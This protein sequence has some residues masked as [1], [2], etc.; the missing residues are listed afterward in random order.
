MRRKRI[1]KPETKQEIN[2]VQLIE[3]FGSEEKCRDYLEQLRW[4][5]GPVCPQCSCDKV[6]KVANR[7]TYDCLACHYQFSVTVGT[8]LQDSHLPLWKWFLTAY[9]MIESKK[10]VSANQMK[11]EIGVSYKTAWYL[12]HRIRAA[13]A[14]AIQEPLTG[15]LEADETLVGGK[16]R[17]MGHGYIGNKK[18]VAGVMC[19]GGGIRLQVIPDRTRETL[20]AFL[21]QHAADDAKAIYTDDWEAYKGIGDANTIHETVSHSIEE[22]VRGDVHTNGIESVWSLLKRAIIGAYHKI[23]HKHL[24]AYLDELEFRF[25]NRDNPRLFEETVK[26]LLSSDVLP[27]EKLIEKKAG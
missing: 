8:I 1:Y 24:D 22:W 5:T 12:C 15:T 10:G 17:G 3:K 23:S 27:Y 19:R 2:L 7:H 21:D 18:T 25:G 20:H 11:R 16:A 9:M 26:R 13:M 6:S 4:T 14:S